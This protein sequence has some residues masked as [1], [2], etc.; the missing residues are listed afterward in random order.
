MDMHYP[1]ARPMMPITPQPR[2]WGELDK[3]GAARRA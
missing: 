1:P 3:S 2:V